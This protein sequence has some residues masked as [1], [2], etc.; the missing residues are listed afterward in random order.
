[1]DI[2]EGHRQRLKQRFAEYGLDNFNDVNVLELLLFLSREDHRSNQAQRRTM[3]RAQVELA[4]RVCKFLSAHLSD[5]ITIDHLAG[6]FHVSPTLLKTSFKGVYGTSVYSYLR[7]LKMHAAA[8]DLRSNDAT[9]L[10]IAGKYGYDNASKFAK[11]FR[12]VTGISPNEYRN[13]A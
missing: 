8:V 9:V 1:M 5:K 11:A 6:A 10:E 4:K 3:S 2:H 13:Q 7:T 12:D